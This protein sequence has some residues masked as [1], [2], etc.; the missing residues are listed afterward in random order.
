MSR[1]TLAVFFS[2]L[3]AFILILATSWSVEY[4]WPDYVH[5]DYG[6]PLVWGVHVL[7]TIHGPVD[8]WRINLSALYID[9]AVWL[10]IMIIGLFLILHFKRQGKSISKG[11]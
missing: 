4:I 9:L 2:I 8:M 1:N 7:N 10:S 6:Y 5:V 11:G 3:C